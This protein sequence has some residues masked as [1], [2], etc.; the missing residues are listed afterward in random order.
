MPC[1]LRV[2]L[3]LQSPHLGV[4]A[5]PQQKLAMCTALDDATAIKDK[6]AL[7]VHDGGQTMCDDQRGMAA[8]DTVK[9]GLDG[10]F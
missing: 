1:T 5:L 9:L 4:C 7:G 10:F 6:D 3:L 2:L 8:G